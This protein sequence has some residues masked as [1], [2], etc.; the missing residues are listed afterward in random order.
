MLE[1]I[2]DALGEVE[3]GCGEVL[4]LEGSAGVGKT[5]LLAQGTRAART[6]GF[7]CG[8]AVG[9]PMEVGLPFG[10]IG[11]AMIELGGS[12]VDHVVELQRLGDPSARLYRM[13]RW[14]ANVAA[15][16]PLLLTLDDLHWADPDSL[17]LLG[18]LARR[19]SGTRIVLLGSL[20]PEP[21]DASALARELLGGG[22]ARVLAVEPLSR[23]ASVALLERAAPGA[24]DSVQSESVWR[25]CAGTPLL[26]QAA[27]RTL[28]GGGSL[29]EVSRE[30]RFGPSLLLERFAGVSGDG[31]AYVRAA[32]ILGVRFSITVAGALAGLDNLQAASE[33]AR[34]VRAR[35][36]EDLGG[37][38]ASF[39]H[40]LFAQALLE[41]M[42]VPERER[43][44]REAFRLLI[45]RGASDAMA[46]EHAVAA[47]LCGDAQ[48]VEVCARAGRLA[49]AQGALQAA[50]AHLAN[51]VELAGPAVSDELLLEYALALGMC[52]RLDTVGEVCGRLFAREHL[53]PFVRAQALSLL[54][55]VATQAG[56]PEEARRRYEEA[57]RAATLAGPATEVA[58]LTDAAVSF[59]F[60]A[61][62]PWTLA[63]ISRALTIVAADDQ[64]TRRPLE[65][66]QA[67]TSL[68][69]G[70]PW[71]VELL[72]REAGRWS[73]RVDGED[74]SSEGGVIHTL[75]VFKFIEDF[76]GTTQVFER[77]YERA[78]ESGVPLLIATL[79]LAYSDTLLRLGRPRE[80]LE[81][82]QR[83][84][85]QSGLSPAPWTDI[86]LAAILTELGC[87]E[88]ARL[89]VEGVR[90]FLARMPSQYYAPVWLWLDLLDARRLMAMG[91]PKHASEGMLHAAS[92][93]RST[94]WREP[95][96]V[97]W[98][99]VAIEAHLA[100]ERT[101]RAHA[102]IEDL[103]SFSER[104]SCRWPR[105]ALELGSAR[106]AGE[107]GAIEVADR[108]FESALEM[109]AELPMPIAHAEALLAHGTHLRRT[110]RPRL[111]REPITRALELCERAGAERVTRLAR[112]E[113][114]ATGGR[115]RRPKTDPSQLTAQEERVASLAAEGMTNVQ[116]ASALHLSPKTVGHH[117]Q[118]VYLKLG[119]HSRRELIRRARP[120]I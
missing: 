78:V 68:M 41:A 86:A 27:A 53:A 103:R 63:M 83:A 114:A 54:A 31:L 44:H 85:T 112:T 14:L 77:E 45:A 12:D 50:S 25:A 96:I 94:G 30:D 79:A 93:A 49:L 4:L 110:G 89:H 47:R 72:V 22:H 56:H 46:A 102:V 106:L 52:G 32:S 43:S 19:V 34:L 51:A 26:L 98:A 17:V 40:P 23:A 118:S 87:E 59:H 115:R 67:Y 90:S 6:V 120:P 91:E 35:L 70:D 69:G 113:L 92:T 24:L 97:P 3:L 73:S 28:G 57:A 62:I 60:A 82:V 105:A 74:A 95:C 2:T 55:R 104:L 101:D 21:D 117:L 65:L 61:P 1:A 10:L 5:S 84:L 108:L 107:E 15:E 16:S 66:V 80:A 42:P 37:G 81:L 36:L 8:S 18:F 111:A 99:G 7:R 48:A 116:V 39:V 58:T 38:D 119:I 33:H 64:P 76:V 100:A 29:P 75:N 9:S 109:H 13:F 11:Q 71:G 20:R 88:D